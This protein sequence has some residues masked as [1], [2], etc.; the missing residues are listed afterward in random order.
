[1]ESAPHQCKPNVAEVEVEK[2]KFI[3][4]K[5]VREDTTASVSQIYKQEFSKILNQGFEIVAEVKTYTNMKGSLCKM[6]RE[7]LGTAQNPKTS[8][9]I[10][11]NEDLLTMSDKS[12]FLL[13][14]ETY[15]GKRALGFSSAEG[16]N[17]LKSN[18]EFFLDGTFKSCPMQF[19]QVFTIHAD[20][21]S[22]DEVTNVLPVAYLLL[23]D[24]T[25]STYV[26]VFF[27][28]KRVG[29]SPKKIKIDFEAALQEALDDVFPEADLSGC[30]YHFNQC[31]WRKIQSLGMA[32]EYKDDEQIRNVCRWCAALAY[33][34]VGKV[35]DAWFIIMENSPVNEKLQSFLDYFTDQW[36]DNP[37]IPKSIWNAFDQRHRTNNPVEGW[38]SKLNK[39]IS[40]PHPNVYFFVQKIKQDAEEMTTKLMAVDIGLPAEKRK[41]KY[42]DL[43][44]RIKQCIEKYL[45]QD[46]FKCL[47]LLAYIAKFE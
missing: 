25:K 42:V 22:S 38:N 29:W 41:K 40:I 5:R 16:K 39:S 46:L 1:M 37:S 45:E 30:I 12:S 2:T 11:L 27:T 19:K 18:E 20:I 36:M 47:R 7:A 10:E 35:D 32:A 43:D 13:F 23:E 17:I 31:L 21:G 6:R 34:P 3:C 24:K 14:D 4:R 8:S 33:L 28:M 15:G 9:E 44:K 26:K